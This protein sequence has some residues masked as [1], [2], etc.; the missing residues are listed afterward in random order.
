LDWFI[1][2]LCATGWGGVVYE[3]EEGGVAR[4]YLLVFGRLAGFLNALT[5]EFSFLSFRLHAML[6]CQPAYRVNLLRYDEKALTSWEMGSNTQS[7]V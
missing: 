2:S 3:A 7:Y 5:R 4:R 6:G 1:A